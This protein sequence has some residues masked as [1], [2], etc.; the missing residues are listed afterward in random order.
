[1][2]KLCP[3]TKLTVEQFTDDCLPDGV[4]SVTK[5]FFDLPVHSLL[6]LTSYEIYIYKI[7]YPNDQDRLYAKS[8]NAPYPFQQ[9]KRG[10][11]I[12]TLLDGYSFVETDRHFCA[13]E[14]NN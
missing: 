11:Y 7:P 3:R 5:E 6:D 12:V 13:E 4:I 1:M 2:K 8:V 9:I 10:E 14:F